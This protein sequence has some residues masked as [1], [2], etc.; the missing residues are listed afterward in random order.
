[1]AS[2][3]KKDIYNIKKFD[4]TNFPIWKEQIQD[5][6]I[7]KGDLDPILEREENAYTDAEWKLL[8][9][10]ARST[11]R[12]HLAESVYFTIV[13]EPTAKV[14]WDNLCANYEN[15]SASNKVYL[16]K[17][18]FDLR[19]KEGGTISRHLN[20]FNKIFSQLTSQ[21]LNFDEEIKCI[22]LQCSLPSSWDTFCTSI[23]NSALNTG[24]VYN[25]VVGS[26]LTEEIRHKSLEPTKQV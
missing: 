10:K 4:G 25:D 2:S 19:M 15:K 16:M 12:L 3:S 1:M 23:S 18:L 7:Q 20:E 13:G 5:V 9:V 14:V 11:I 26:L 8:D 24:L 22:F 6:L 17:K 21:G